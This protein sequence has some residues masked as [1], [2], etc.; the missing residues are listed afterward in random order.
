MHIVR[1]ILTFVLV[2]VAVPV[3]VVLWYTPLG[4]GYVDLTPEELRR[5]AV[6]LEEHGRP[7]LDFVVEAFADRD[8]VIV[9]ESH[10]VA[11]DALFVQELI[12]A[13]YHRAGV[14]HL[15]IEFGVQSD[16]PMVD[17][18]LSSSAFDRG[19][20]QEVLVHLDLGWLYE[21]Y[22]GVLEAAWKLNATL[23]QE[24]PRFRVL[25][26]TP[27]E[28]Q[29]VGK[30]A[31]MARLVLEQVAA[32]ERVL[33]YCGSHHGFTRYRQPMPF[34]ALYLPAD[35]PGRMGNRLYAALG[36]RVAFV[37]LHAPCAKRWAFFAWPLYRRPLLLPFGGVIDRAHADLGEPVGF[38]TSVE[39]FAGLT[40]DVSY[41]ALHREPLTLEQFA[42]GYVVLA[43]MS[44]R[45]AVR[46]F[47]GLDEE[48]ARAVRANGL[49]PEKAW[50]KTDRAGY[51]E[52][53][54]WPN[55]RAFWVGAALV[56]AVWG[57]RR[58]RRRRKAGI[59]MPR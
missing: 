34:E 2:V 30:D 15:L 25:L 37:R 54:W 59:T 12:P 32:G 26:G 44:E 51:D 29:A 6:A 55:V 24:A 16:Q 31:D 27:G 52:P 3:A 42:D 21:E 11:Q 9:G 33:V 50:A 43:A 40:D 49:Y 18:L 47:V 39:P 38:W 48:H 8:V 45:R 23:S 1:R 4:N 17:R 28:R 46:P 5:H 7:P 36:D 14:R 10:R 20:A 41:Y 19:S 13:V 56:A 35:R 57:L 22:L 53:Q 58:W